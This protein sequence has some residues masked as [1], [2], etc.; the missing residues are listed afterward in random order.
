MS[1]KPPLPAPRP[2]R[3][4]RR[5][6]AR[7]RPRPARARRRPRR[8]RAAGAR[9]ATS[10]QRQSSV[11]S[12]FSGEAAPRV[13]LDRLPELGVT[14]HRGALAAVDTDAHEVTHHRRRATRLR[15]ADRRARARARSRACPARRRSAARSAPARSRARCAP[16]ASARCSSLPPGSGWPL[17]IY[18]LALLAAREFPDGLEIA[19]VS[20][21]A[22]A[23]RRL[24]AGRLRRARAA[25]RP[26]RRRVHRRH[27]CAARS[28]AA[29]SSPTTAG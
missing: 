1:S 15:P 24:R 5:R 23:A 6:R 18:E 25:A 22:A 14:R 11:L 17:P 12:P 26:R 16:R 19:V 2:R 20:P 27:A 8:H 7:G 4:R 10:S 28:S 13:P 9:P 3:R 21:G 29:R